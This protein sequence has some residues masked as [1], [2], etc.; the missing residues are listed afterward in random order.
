MTFGDHPV[1]SVRLLQTLTAIVLNRPMTT[2]RNYLQPLTPAPQTLDLKTILNTSNRRSLKMS[3]RPPSTHLP[4]A[5]HT[6]NPSHLEANKHPIRTPLIHPR[7]L[8]R[9]SSRTHH[10]TRHNLRSRRLQRRHPVLARIH[11]QYSILVHRL[12]NIRHTMRH[13]SSNR[14]TWL[15]REGIQMVSTG[16]WDVSEQIETHGI[17][18]GLRDI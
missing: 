7:N 11:I 16:N 8:R 12:G 17:E 5:P 2:H 9:L 18:R 14:D 3:T 13:E 15:R 4:T 1:V 10:I 6:S